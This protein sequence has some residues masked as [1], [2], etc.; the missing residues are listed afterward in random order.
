[1]KCAK[2]MLDPLSLCF[3]SFGVTQPSFALDH[4]SVGKISL[5]RW[6][7]YL[8]G[9]AGTSWCLKAFCPFFFLTG[10]NLENIEKRKMKM[11]YPILPPEE[12]H[13]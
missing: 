13:H 3:V 6:V 1:M 11:K 2:L 10:E 4:Q 9:L 8:K 5:G 7:E 12:K